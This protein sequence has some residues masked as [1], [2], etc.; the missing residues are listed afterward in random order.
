MVFRYRTPLGAVMS[1]ALASG[2]SALVAIILTL[3][4]MVLL[5]FNQELPP[6]I[7]PTVP[8][9]ARFLLALNHRMIISRR[10]NRLISVIKVIMI[11]LI[12]DGITALRR[13]VV[14]KRCAG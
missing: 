6:L 13:P 8:L 9:V 12:A 11:P 4:C 10:R 2:L 3:I 14:T 1:A 5:I 7:M